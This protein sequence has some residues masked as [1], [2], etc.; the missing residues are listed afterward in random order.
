LP[1]RTVTA[2]EGAAGSESHAVQLARLEGALNLV[3]RLVED[4][5]PRVSTHDAAIASLNLA[6]QRLDNEAGWRDKTVESTARALKDAK[7]A[8]DA[9]MRSEAAKAEQGWTP[10]ARLFAVISA[11]ATVMVIVSV[12]ADLKP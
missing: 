2:Q 3:H 12:Y 9:A 10:M 6:A 11:I 4:M 7:E 5:A 1:A 8:Q